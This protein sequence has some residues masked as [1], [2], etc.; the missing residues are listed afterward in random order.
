MKRRNGEEGTAVDPKSALISQNHWTCNPSSPLFHCLRRALMCWS[1]LL[2]PFDFNR[3][4]TEKEKSAE[5]VDRTPDLMIFSHTLSQL[6]YLGCW[7]G[8]FSVP[9]MRS[10]HFTTRMDEQR[11]RVPIPIIPQSQN[12]ISPNRGSVY[13]D[14]PIPVFIPSLFP[15]MGLS[16]PFQFWFGL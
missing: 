11:E 6:S 10:S 8:H 3:I 5:K 9:Y 7:F 2:S 16:T 1:S 4:P 12:Q 14:N 13:G 15:F